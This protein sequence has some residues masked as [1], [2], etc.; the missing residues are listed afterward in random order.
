MRRPGISLLAAIA[1]LAVPATPRSVDA[2]ETRQ[3]T[4]TVAALVQRGAEVYSRQCQRCH[5][6][7]SP[8]E[9]ND[10]EWII[11]MQHMQARANITRQQ[12]REA[13]AFLMAS[14]R[15]AR[16]TAGS[17]GEPVSLSEADITE[18]LIR[19]GR[20]VYNLRGG[21]AACHGA[22]LGGGPIAPDL[23]DASWKNGDGSLASILRVIRNGV[24]GTAMA[25]YPGGITE[26]E[27]TSVAAYVWAVAS[28]RTSP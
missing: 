25:A 8:G 20:Q 13:L 10:R 17:A 6:P 18:D 9:R 4:D 19:Q 21:C 7:R 1:A 11:I 5:I 26:E 12:A 23:S 15:S 27:A 14:N 16:R 24:E 28:G 2:Q 3:D 22:D